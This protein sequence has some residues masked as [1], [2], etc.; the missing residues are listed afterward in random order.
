MFTTGILACGA[1]AGKLDDAPT[2]A[3]VDEGSSGASEYASVVDAKDNV[4]V[5][6]VAL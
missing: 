4:S 1:W 2:G 5:V 3:V 6:A